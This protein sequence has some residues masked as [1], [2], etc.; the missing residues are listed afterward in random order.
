MVDLAAFSLAAFVACALRFDGTIAPRISPCPGNCNLHLGS[1]EV[2]GLSYWLGSVGALEI[3][4]SKR[5]GAYCLSE[6]VG[7]I[8]R[9]HGHYIHVLGVGTIPRSVYV[10]DWLVS[11]LLTLG[12]RLAVRLIVACSKE[13]IEREPTD[14]DTDL[15][16]WSRGTSVWCESCS[17]MNR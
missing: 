10:L 14:K 1:C 11:C 15:R 3:Y 5:C 6:F 16:C 12:A 2:D 17:R 8:G 4:V 9:R 13:L 7:V